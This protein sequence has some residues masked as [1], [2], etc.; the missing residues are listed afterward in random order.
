MM[1]VTKTTFNQLA[2]IRRE[3]CLATKPM[4]QM[5][6]KDGTWGKPFVYRFGTAENAVERLESMNPGKKFRLAD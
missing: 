1:K 2:A 5:M 3:K 4:V 6:K